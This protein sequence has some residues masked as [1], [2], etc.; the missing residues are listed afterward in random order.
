MYTVHN[1]TVCLG[2]LKKQLGR[3]FNPPTSPAIQTLIRSHTISACLAF[4]LA[5]HWR[6]FC[7]LFEGRVEDWNMAT[8]LRIDARGDVSEQNTVIGMSCPCQSISSGFLKW[9]K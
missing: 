4:V 2:G 8:L 3:G 5:Q 1:L 6:E 7:N 9:S